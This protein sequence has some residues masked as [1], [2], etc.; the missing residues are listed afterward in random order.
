MSELAIPLLA[1]LAGLL[2]GLGYF[3]LLRRSVGLLLEPGKR[4]LGVALT[5]GRLAVAA[6][7]L[8]LAARLGAAALLAALA[9]F[10]AARFVALRRNKEA[11][12]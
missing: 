11:A 12:P 6:L 2:F 9:G 5:L 1:A 10:V 8:Y 7:L 3:A 4:G